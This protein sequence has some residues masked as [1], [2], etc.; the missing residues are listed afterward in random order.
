MKNKW[1][2]IILFVSLLSACNFTPEEIFLL[3][4]KIPTLPPTPYMSPVK[5]PTVIPTMPTPT[6]TSTPTFV[7]AKS[8]TPIQPTQAEMTEMTPTPVLLLKLTPDTV[9]PTIQMKG[10][11]RVSADGDVFYTGAACQPQSIKF[12]A[13]AADPANTEYVVLFVRLKSKQTGAKSDW[14]S[15]TM[16]NLGTG[17]FTHEL[18]AKEIKS[19]ES[20]KDAWVDYQFV[21]TNIADNEVGRTAIFSEKLTLLTCVP[22]PTPTV[23]PTATVLKP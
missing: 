23:E 9:T 11:V 5:T 7:G 15:I 14:T 21:A 18:T 19:R 22:T 12:T 13:Q 1:V 6:Y 16:D 4:T 17:A 2:I 3:P 10:F 8:P 20:F